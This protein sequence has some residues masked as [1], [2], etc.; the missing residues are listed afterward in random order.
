MYMEAS[1]SDELTSHPA[2][3]DTCSTCRVIHGCLDAVPSCTSDLIVIG[4]KAASSP[5]CSQADICWAMATHPSCDGTCTPGTQLKNTSARGQ[6]PAAILSH[7]LDEV[8]GV[9]GI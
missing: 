3:T 2:N 5:L 9:S 1:I 6:Q 7:G 4:C 8:C